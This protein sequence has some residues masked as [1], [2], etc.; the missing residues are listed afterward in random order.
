MRCL[1][2]RSRGIINKQDNLQKE[3]DHLAR[4]LKQNGYP[5]NFI[6]NASAP[7]TQKTADTNSPDKGQEE[8]GPLVVIFYVH[9]MN[10]D[11]GQVCRK[12][13]IRVVFKSGWTLHSTFEGYITSW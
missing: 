9:G 1:Y 4:I 10:E 11:I 5:A 8:K 2:D 7:P 3:V 6:R 13:N 12:V